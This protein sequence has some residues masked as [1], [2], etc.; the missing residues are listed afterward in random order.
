M[1]E[2]SYIDINSAILPLKIAADAAE[3][4]GAMSAVICVNGENGYSLW[5]GSHVPEIGSAI[6]T[7][8]ALAQELSRITRS[9]YQ[10]IQASLTDGSFGYKLMLPD[11]EVDLELRAEAMAHWCQGFLLGL[12]YSG[13]TDLKQFSG[14]LAEIINDIT[15]ISQISVG[16][17]DYSE[18]EEQSITELI[19]YLRVGVMLF[20]ETLPSHIEQGNTSVH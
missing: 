10:Q 12:G 17:L 7:G 15:E 14:E 16:Q 19:E 3:F 20:K 11:D 9:L 5:L 8:N 4:H 1:Q 18:D 13:I 6:V 2:F